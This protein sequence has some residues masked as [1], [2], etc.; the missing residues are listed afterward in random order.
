MKILLIVASGK[1][2]RFGGFPKAF[3]RI[4]NTCH[5]ANTIQHALK[6]YD[7]VYLAVNNETYD[8]YKDLIPDCTMIHINTGQGDAHSLLKC[9]KIIKELEKELKEI[10]VCWGD[11]VFVDE[12]PFSQLLEQRRRADSPVVI[13]CAMDQKPYAWFEVSDDMCVKKAHFA[14]EEG[15][16]ESGIHDQSLF[17]FDMEFAV[18]YLSEYQKELGIPDENHTVY[19]EK[20]VM[21][22]L[23]SFEYLYSE[24]RF[25]GAK[26]AFIESGKVFS[27]NT[28]EEL[29]EIK[30]IL[31]PST[32]EIEGC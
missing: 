20:R 22:L 14:R 31:L 13:A 30:N 1:S 3:C 9:L 29:S 8:S 17:L 16:V 2:S 28:Q 32:E 23:Y 19:D 18:T 15:M 7:K 6:V 27:F 11:A 26:I 10:S 4:G 24:S 12:K 5:V 25:P 21:K